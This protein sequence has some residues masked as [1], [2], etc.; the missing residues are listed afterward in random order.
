MIVKFFITAML[1]L[2]FI[3]PLNAT[4]LTVD[5]DFYGYGDLTIYY[6]NTTYSDVDAGELRVI[7]ENS[8]QFLPAFCVDLD[9]AL[10][11]GENIVD[12]FQLSSGYATN[13]K[14]VEWLMDK[15][16]SSALRSY[17]FGN[18]AAGAGLQLAIWEV[19]YDFNLSLSDYNLSKEPIVTNG[20][21]DYG[22]FWYDPSTTNSDTNKW[23]NDYITLLKK[24]AGSFSYT[25]S[26]NYKVAKLSSNGI[27]KQDLLIAV[28]PAPTTI[29]LLSFGLLGLSAVRRRKNN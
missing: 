11:Y 16:L 3:L 25:S 15:S 9:T 17:T 18:D 28:V 5:Q 22:G 2:C 8:T 29:M 7:L 1:I 12:D 27:D 24:N 20:I 21:T 23:Y 10:F 19:L 26:E 13:G 4:T 6:N 14:Y